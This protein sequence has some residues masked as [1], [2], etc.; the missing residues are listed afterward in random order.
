[1]QSRRNVCAIYHRHPLP[2]RPFEQ[3]EIG[4][5]VSTEAMRQAGEFYPFRDRATHARRVEAIHRGIVRM[6]EAG[7]ATI[8]SERVLFWNPLRGAYDEYTHAYHSMMV[9]FMRDSFGRPAGR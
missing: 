4:D 5:L 2:A 7:A 9:R 6:L 1:M 3:R 8:E